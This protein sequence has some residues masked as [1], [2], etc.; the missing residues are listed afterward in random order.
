MASKAAKLSTALLL[1]TVSACGAPAN[2]A[3]VPKAPAE[4]A[5]VSCRKKAEDILGGRGTCETAI[6]HGFSAPN[7]CDTLFN[8]FGT[9]LDQAQDCESQAGDALSSCGDVLTEETRQALKEKVSSHR[10]FKASSA[11]G[12]LSDYTAECSEAVGYE[13]T[14]N[15]MAVELVIITDME[16]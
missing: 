1:G 2:T 7:P 3:E 15:L 8:L 9:V 4:V 14:K 11:R 5:A 16:K 13:A 12:T 6:P 10:S